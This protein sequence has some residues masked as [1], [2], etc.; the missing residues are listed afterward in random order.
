MSLLKKAKYR[1]IFSLIA[2]FLLSPYVSAQT[3]SST[4]LQEA[5]ESFITK[6]VH[7]KDN[8]QLMV[9][10]LPI[11][12]RINARQC[13]DPLSL[14]TP[15]TP[16]FNRQVTVK[17]QCSSASS[18]WT[19]FTHVRIEEL[20][21]VVISTQSI[22][23][24]ELISADHLAIE[25]K[26]KHFIR[27]N[28]LQSFSS[29]L[30]SRAKRIIREG[31]SISLPQICMVCKGDMVTIYAK[32]RTLTIKTSGQALQDG[33]VGEQIRVKNQKSGKT[34]SARVKDVESVEVNI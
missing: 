26:A 14:S 32:T 27:A 15:A 30:G 34:I 9:K 31:T 10:A 16:P 28:N 21:P 4:Q 12:S 13:E 1:Y 25:Y 22:N 11:D 3:F 6:Q 7:K 23:K 19:L 33:N 18:R 17:I 20:F 2:Y 24:G 29:L 8:S 5:A